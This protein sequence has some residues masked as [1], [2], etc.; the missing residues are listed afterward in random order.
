MSKY[1]IVGNHMSRLICMKNLEIIKG[2]KR[3]SEKKNESDLGFQRKKCHL[4]RSDIYID[5]E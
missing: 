4:R 1:H 3:T 2:V 5:F